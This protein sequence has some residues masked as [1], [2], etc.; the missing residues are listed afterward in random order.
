VRRTSEP[1]DYITQDS[2]K[3]FGNFSRQKGGAI[4]G[5]INRLADQR[6]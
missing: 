5:T 6:E 4:F 1:R 2:V 3:I